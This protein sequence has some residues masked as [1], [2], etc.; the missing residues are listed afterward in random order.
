MLQISW[1][2][3]LFNINIVVIIIAIM[4]KAGRIIG[5]MQMFI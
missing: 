1:L 4:Q 3:I 5:P 2:D